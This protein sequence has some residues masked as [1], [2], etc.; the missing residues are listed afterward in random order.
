MKAVKIVA[1]PKST[2]KTKKITVIKAQSMP[3][4]MGKKKC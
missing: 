2:P 1:K 4:K 3:M